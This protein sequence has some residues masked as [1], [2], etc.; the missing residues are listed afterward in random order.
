MRKYL[1]NIGGFW[2]GFSISVFLGV[3][4]G[5]W[6]FWVIII[7]TIVLFSLDKN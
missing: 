6:Q 1:G 7:P 2:L 5:N 3:D 4:L